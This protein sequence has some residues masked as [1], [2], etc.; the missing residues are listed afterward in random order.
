MRILA[1]SLLSVGVLFSGSAFAFTDECRDIARQYAE[2]PNS[3]KMG[4][5]DILMA[6]IGDTMRD[7]AQQRTEPAP[8]TFS[9]NAVSAIPLGNNASTPSP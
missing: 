8:T 6:C 3:V 7:T 9:A 1:T 4:D 2:Q 5:L